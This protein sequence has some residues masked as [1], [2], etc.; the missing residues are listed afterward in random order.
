MAYTTLIGKWRLWLSLTLNRELAN[1]IIEGA[2][3]ARGG[4]RLGTGV[5]SD[6]MHHL[7]DLIRP[8]I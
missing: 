1:C 5:P 2:R 6:G 4:E 7:F 3:N 8:Q